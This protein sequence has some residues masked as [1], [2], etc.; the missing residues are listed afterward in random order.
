MANL[1][2]ARTF[3]RPI[4]LCSPWI[5]DF[6]IFDNSN[7]QFSS[8]VPA[9]ADRMRVNL[10][11]CLA[12]LVLENEVRVVSK[13]TPASEAFS[14]M[15]ALSKSGVQLRMCD[16]KLHEKGFLTPLFYLEGSMNIT[17]S[18]VMLNAEKVIFHSGDEPEVRSRIQNA[19]LEFER[20][21]RLLS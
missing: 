19:Y 12:Q 9:A 5:S 21:W 14:R 15:V 11:D 4:Y 1:L 18:G 3:E 2:L 7:G 8:L 16:D 13:K 17:F 10:S 20:R 6:P